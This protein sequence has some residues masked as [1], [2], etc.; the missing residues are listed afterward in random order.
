M[1]RYS[2]GLML[3]ILLTCGSS[4][5]DS[6]PDS[7][8]SFRIFPDGYS[9]TLDT[10]LFRV[11]PNA[12]DPLK[13]SFLATYNKGTGLVQS[14]V[15]PL[16]PGPVGAAWVPGRAAFVV[17]HGE[18]TSLFERD[19]AGRGYTGRALPCPLGPVYGSCSW[20]PEGRWLAVTCVDRDDPS[21][22]RKL[23]VYDL[24]RNTF[25]LSDITAKFQLPLWKDNT[26]LLVMR[27]DEVVEVTVESGPPKITATVP[28]QEGAD[29]FYG[30]FNGQ[31]L[32]WRGK[33]VCLGPRTLI[34][35]EEM[36]T[37][38]VLPTETTIFVAASTTNLV[39]FDRQGREI[40]RTDPGRMIQFGP[41]AEDPNTVYGLANSTLVQVSI[42]NGQLSVRDLCDLRKKMGNLG[43][44][45]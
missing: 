22:S 8:I 36:R 15:H 44:P 33:K 11:S 39:A 35:F 38:S 27:G 6:E 12:R 10:F 31:A 32:V 41:I 25:V 14:L 16:H 4:C 37:S 19:R 2:M 23:G 28:I 24:Q 20:S 1:L 43:T 13:D 5:R 26:T 34:G 30:M 18:R 7:S 45:Y 40:G 17:T 29:W 42:E 9:S 21:W 3:V